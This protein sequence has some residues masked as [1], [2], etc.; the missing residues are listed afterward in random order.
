MH[1]NIAI[2]ERQL[3]PGFDTEFKQYE[4]FGR[5]NGWFLT[6]T[7]RPYQLPTAMLFVTIEQAAM[8]PRTKRR[9]HAE[10]AA[11]QA[12]VKRRQWRVVKGLDKDW[13]D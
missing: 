1:D 8:L 10:A 7:W 5:R 6:D 2:Q 4:G 3:F 9:A 13:N 12:E 11:C